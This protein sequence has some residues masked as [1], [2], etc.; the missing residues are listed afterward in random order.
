MSFYHDTLFYFWILD[1]T[2]IYIR[3]VKFYAANIDESLSMLASDHSVSRI[4]QS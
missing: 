3:S 4:I 2:F 1:L